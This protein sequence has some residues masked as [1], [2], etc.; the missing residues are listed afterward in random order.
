[1]QDL[2][3]KL[4]VDDFKGLNE[5]KEGYDIRVY[6]GIE[7]LPLR[8][9][10]DYK[11]VFLNDSQF[12]L[13]NFQEADQ[14]IAYVDAGDDN[15]IVLSNGKVYYKNLISNQES[16]EM[17]QQNIKRCEN[18][19]EIR[20]Q[21]SLDH[22]IIND[23]T[24]VSIPLSS[25]MLKNTLVNKRIFGINDQ[26]R[27]Q[28]SFNVDGISMIVKITNSKNM[29]NNILGICFEKDVFIKAVANFV[30]NHDGKEILD[31]TGTISDLFMNL[32]ALIKKS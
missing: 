24:L 15:F 30:I 3:R 13:E 2:K 8:V 19:K 28:Y 18:N 10:D 23:N 25:Q 5:I 4:E 29:S 6:V 12:L 22:T 7:N 21:G 16:V 32:S 17:V 26:L 14:I 31:Y 11:K 1:M 27:I 9:D 20:F